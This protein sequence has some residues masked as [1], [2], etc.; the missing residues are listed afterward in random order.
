MFAFSSRWDCGEQN[1][2]RHRQRR[3]FCAAEVCFVT[4]WRRLCADSLDGSFWFTMTMMLLK[5]FTRT[6][7]LRS[8]S[9]LI[10]NTT[11]TLRVAASRQSAA[12]LV[13]SSSSNH[14]VFAV[15]HSRTFSEAAA[16]SD[17][18]IVPGIGRGKTSTGYVRFF[19]KFSS[20]S[21]ECHVV[22]S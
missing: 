16:A 14:L 21:L 3:Y 11:S 17:K 13:G 19:C 6:T 12:A 18:P 1:K 9:L 15:N 20:G 4:Q 8:S 2:Q 5:P 22:E 10:R 7:F